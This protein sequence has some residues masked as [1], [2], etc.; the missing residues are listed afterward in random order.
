MMT[1]GVIVLMVGFR[2]YIAVQVVLVVVMMG[3]D[4]DV[5]SRLFAK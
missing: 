5:L 3:V 4:S 1:P 2:H